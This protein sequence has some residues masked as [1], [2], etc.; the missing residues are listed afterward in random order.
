MCES[1]I[2]SACG[3]VLGVLLSIAGIYTIK[4]FEILNINANI[5]AIIVCFISAILCGVLSGYLP[6]KRAAELDPIDA[7]RWE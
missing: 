3:G 5:T 1:L 2:T 7:I 4:H 6:A